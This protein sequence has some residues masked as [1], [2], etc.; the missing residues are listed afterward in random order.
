MTVEHY[1]ADTFAPAIATGVTLI[2]FWATWC[3]PC[4]MMAPVLDGLSEDYPDVKFVKVNVDEAGDLAAQYGV[5]SIP[6]FLF[7]KNGEVVR[8]LVGGMRPADFE[9]AI[10]E[11]IG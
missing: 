3:G 6:N 9:A 5:M 8:N 10:R 2:D 7:F 4:K 11:V 1:D